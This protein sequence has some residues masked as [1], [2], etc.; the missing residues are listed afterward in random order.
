MAS[1]HAAWHNQRLEKHAKK[2]VPC[3]LHSKASIRLHIYPIIICTMLRLAAVALTAFMV[4][5]ASAYDVPSLTP[6][7]YDKLT[8]M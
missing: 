3:P 8:G 7:N 4:S 2:I 5:S 1:P 6:D